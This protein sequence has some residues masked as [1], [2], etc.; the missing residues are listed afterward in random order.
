MRAVRRSVDE[1]AG[2]DGMEFEAL[3]EATS[4]APDRSAARDAAT[5][6]SRGHHIV[7]QRRQRL[8][9]LLIVVGLG[10]MAGGGWLV[11]AS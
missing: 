1:A 9:I 11:F 4:T 10:L 8:G 6:W 3:R 2:A 7:D 5:A